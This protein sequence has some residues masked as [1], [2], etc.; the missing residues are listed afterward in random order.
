MEGRC[1]RTTS[2]AWTGLVLIG[3]SSSSGSG[4]LRPVRTSCSMCQL[5]NDTNRMETL[6]G[7]SLP[8]SPGR[9][10]S[11]STCS[12]T[13]R[14]IVRIYELICERGQWQLVC[15]SFYP[16]GSHRKWVGCVQA[17]LSIVDWPPIPEDGH[18]KV[19]HHRVDH[20]PVGQM[21]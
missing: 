13:E 15:A 4:M 21:Q 16:S 7:R 11:R 5:T 19:L 1:R 10:T 12:R 2:T 9:V 18:L 17:F 8:P 14:R 3:L 6:N 20:L